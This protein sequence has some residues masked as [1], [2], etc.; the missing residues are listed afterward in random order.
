MVELGLF[1]AVQATAALVAPVLDPLAG[2]LIVTTGAF[3]GGTVTVQVTL[4]EP[5]PPA[6]V[7]STTTVCEPAPRPAYAFGDVHAVAGAPSSEQAVALGPFVEPNS[8]DAVVA[9]VDEP[10]T[11]ALIVTTGG[12]GG[13]GGAITD[14]VAESLPVPPSL[15]AVTTTVCEPSASPL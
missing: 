15:A 14:H 11:G 10:P 2:A 8:T 1:V 7:A 3:G 4:A 6:L 5:V 12:S 9:V 13:G